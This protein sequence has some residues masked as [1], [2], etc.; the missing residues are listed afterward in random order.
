MQLSAFL[1]PSAVALDIEASDRDAVLAALVE[2]LGVTGRQ[3][4]T[5][6]RLLTRREVLGSTAVGRGIAIPHCRTLVVPRVRMAYAR[7]A[8]PLPWESL[9]GDPVRHVFLIVAPPVEV[10]NQYLPA[11]ARLAHFARD[12]GA[13]RDLDRLEAPAGIAAVLAAH[14]G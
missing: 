2:L 7:L 10:S 4:T 14:G 6:L 13:T 11:L 9:D 8:T 3:R 12:P 5:L 1:A